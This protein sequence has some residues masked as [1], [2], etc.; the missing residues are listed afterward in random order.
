MPERDDH[1]GGAGAGGAGDRP[2]TQQECR[3]RDTTYSEPVLVD[4][5]YPRGS[6]RIKLPLVML[7]CLP[8]MLGSN[9]CVLIGK[10]EAQLATTSEAQL[11]TTSECPLDPGVISSLKA[12]RRS[13]LVQEQLS[14]NR[15]SVETDSS[16]GIVSV[17]VTS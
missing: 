4:I 8:I 12:R 10:S 6:K 16:K 3:L 17:S 5:E 14:K 15:I 1:G 7:A 13:F 9:K 2:V 11:A